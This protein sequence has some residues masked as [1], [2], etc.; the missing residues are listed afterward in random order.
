MATAHNQ[1]AATA[2]L[3][4]V[5]HQN[6]HHQHNLA[7]KKNIHVSHRISFRFSVWAD[8]APSYAHITISFTRN[9]FASRIAR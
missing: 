2:R 4:T 6:K 7:K 9:P 8:H 1:N 5:R 3:R